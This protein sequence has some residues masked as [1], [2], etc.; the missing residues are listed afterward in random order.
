M[1]RRDGGRS[2]DE[3]TGLVD[4]V[5]A[6]TRRGGVLGRPA[7]VGGRGD[8]PAGG[9][10]RGRRGHRHERRPGRHHPAHVRHGRRPVRPRARPATGGAAASRPCSTRRVG[11][12]AAPT[13]TGCGPRAT[14]RCRSGATSAARPVPGCV[15]GW[16][17]LHERFGRLPLADVLAPAI[18]PRRGRPRL[19]P[20]L[21]FMIPSL[22]GIEGCDELVDADP[23]AATLRRPGAGPPAADDRRPTAGTASTSASSA[24]PCSPPAAASTPRPTSPAARPTG[25]AGLAL[26]VWGHRRLDHPARTRRAT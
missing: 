3:V 8:G 25:C 2:V 9:R 10:E 5:R 23:D 12:A 24:G 7:G 16:L 17:A 20:L 14:R 6:G 19:S 1:I 22:A 26:D 4:R 15:D 13:P 18:T 11:P 21:A